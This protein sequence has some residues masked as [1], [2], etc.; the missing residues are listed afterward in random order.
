[1]NTLLIIKNKLTLG[2]GTCERAASNGNEKIDWEY[3]DIVLKS[4]EQNGI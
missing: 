2:F 1:M 4:S 3:K